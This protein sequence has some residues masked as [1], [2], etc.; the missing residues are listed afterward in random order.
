MTRLTLTP[1]RLRWAAALLTIASLSACAPLVLGGAV[2]GA[3]M[4]T[5][6]RTSGIQ[7]EDQTIELK[8]SN[9]IKEAIGDQGHINVNAYNRRV[10]LT[11]EVPNESDRA[12]AQQAAAAVENV[13]NVY[14]E[15]MVSLNSSFSTRANDVL[16][17]SKVKA[18]LVDARDIISNAFSVVTERGDV[19]I[20]G[21]VTE[22]EANR[23]A[24]LAAS[25]KGVNR[26]VK[27]MQIISED[28]LARKLPRPA[29]TST[30]TQ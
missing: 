18:T 12:A 2:G 20:M 27:V 15:L 13:D 21:L 22:R 4:A 29:N 9:R 17:A 30:T 3:F 5:D 10:L 8:V 11:G 24:E 6:R 19:Y 25:V 28:E 7:L 1:T 26:V 16:L 14:N 23:A